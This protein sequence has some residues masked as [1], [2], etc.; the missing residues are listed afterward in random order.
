MKKI[1]I[2]FAIFSLLTGCCAKTNYDKGFSF[3]YSSQS[4]SS[5][6]TSSWS[7]TSN[8]GVLNPNSS[9]SSQKKTTILE[10]ILIQRQLIGLKMEKI[11]KKVKILKIYL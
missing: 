2:L 7:T 1:I 3:N 6:N 9:Y 4:N 5:Y 8:N 10:Q 11:L